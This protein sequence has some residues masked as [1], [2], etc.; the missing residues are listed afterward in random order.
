MTVVCLNGK[1]C[2]YYSNSAPYSG[3]CDKECITVKNCYY[4][5]KKDEKGK[6]QRRIGW[7]KWE[8]ENVKNRIKD[9]KKTVKK[10]DK[11]LK[12]LLRELDK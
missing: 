6:L 11:E 1:E 5:E 2:T 4:F 3:F 12:E 9:S 8:I 10:L 7:I